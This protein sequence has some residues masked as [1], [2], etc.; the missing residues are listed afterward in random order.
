MPEDR[1][2]CAI[3]AFMAQV[4][5]LPHEVRAINI[6]AWMVL[7]LLANEK[8]IMVTSFNILLEHLTCNVFHILT[9][10][11]LHFLCY[12]HLV[13]FCMGGGL[14]QLVIAKLSFKIKSFC[15]L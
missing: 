4:Q 15:F 1:G 14:I 11:L 5:D 8:E 13:L 12:L 2:N 9:L 3:L 6:R 7:Y 10:S